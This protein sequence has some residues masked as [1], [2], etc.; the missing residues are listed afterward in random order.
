[1]RLG[2]GTAEEITPT[3]ALKAYLESKKVPAERAKVLREYG[4]R[5]IEEQESGQI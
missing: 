4:E 1:M 5:L 3:Q 2:E